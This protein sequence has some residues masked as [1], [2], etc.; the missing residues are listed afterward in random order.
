[1]RIIG[2]AETNARLLDLGAEPIIMTAVE[3]NRYFHSEID[4]WAKVVKASG[5]K[6]D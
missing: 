2:S 1:M 3:A 4:K 6:A 5:A